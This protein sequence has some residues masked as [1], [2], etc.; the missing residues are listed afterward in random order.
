MQSD[1]Y[2]LWIYKSIFNI[3]NLPETMWNQVTQ[4]ITV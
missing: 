4:K 3:K 2:I 1:V